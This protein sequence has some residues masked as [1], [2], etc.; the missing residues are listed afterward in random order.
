MMPQMILAII[1]SELPLT[2]MRRPILL[3]AALDYMRLNL[4]SGKFT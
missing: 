1:T 4:F 3:E 2:K